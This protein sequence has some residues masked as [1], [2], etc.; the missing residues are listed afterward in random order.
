MMQQISGLIVLGITSGLAPCAS[1]ETDGPVTGR[2][3]VE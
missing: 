1:S 2:H 3:E